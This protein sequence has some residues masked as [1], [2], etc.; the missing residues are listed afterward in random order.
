MKDAILKQEMFS[1]PSD[2][3]IS[4]NLKKMKNTSVS[5]ILIIC[6]Y[7]AACQPIKKGILKTAGEYIEPQLETPTSIL[8]YCD[9][10]KVKYEKLFVLKSE[11]N[12]RNFTQTYKS[13]PG[14]YVFD[15]EYKPVSA[16]YKKGCSW[17]T[18]RFIFDTTM[19]ITTIE[20]TTTFKEI[21]SNFNLVDAKSDHKSDFYILCSW[22]KFTPKLT[23][24]LFET[25]NKQK[26]EN[27]RDV[28]YYL[29][30]VDLQKS[31]ENQ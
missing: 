17:A 31:W 13:I 3:S 19:T 27:L 12:F 18:I 21:M 16:D 29:L 24:S 20:D 1:N 4:L 26:A 9:S 14:I 22:A 15:K 30:D 5:I 8:T 23:K 10:N 2:N 7:I 25:I 28:S 11:D 6:L